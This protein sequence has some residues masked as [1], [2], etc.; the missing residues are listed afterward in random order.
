MT[1][2]AAANAALARAR[3]LAFLELFVGPPQSPR[4]EPKLGALRA[5]A[6]LRHV[7]ISLGRTLAGGGLLAVGFTVEQ[8]AQFDALIAR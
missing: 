2:S 3:S 4:L 1:P 8:I 7:L 5:Y 6:E